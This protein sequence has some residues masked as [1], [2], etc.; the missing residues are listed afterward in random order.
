MH[1]LATIRRLNREAMGISTQTERRFLVLLSD[2]LF[3]HGI[4]IQLGANVEEAAD[5][6]ESRFRTLEDRDESSSSC[7]YVEGERR[8]S[9]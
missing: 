7:T 5:A 1:D 6:I 3:E 4:S 9:A 8:A 2:A